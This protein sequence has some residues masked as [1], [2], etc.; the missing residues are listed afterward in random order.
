MHALHARLITGVNSR[1][2]PHT[3]LANYCSFIHLSGCQSAVTVEGLQIRLAIVSKSTNQLK[4]NYQQYSGMR[5]AAIVPQ[6]G[7]EW[8]QRFLDSPHQ[9]GI[10]FSLFAQTQWLYH[11]KLATLEWGY[12]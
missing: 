10:L 11:E 2:L 12:V 3:A 9:I 5:L 1:N 6:A 4:K 7:M 8:Y